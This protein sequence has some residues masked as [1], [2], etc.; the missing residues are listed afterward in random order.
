MLQLRSLDQDWSAEQVTAKVQGLVAFFRSRGLQSGQVVALN[1]ALTPD[2]IFVLLALW[3][4][5]AVVLPL[6]PRLPEA[7]LT[8]ALCQVEATFYLSERPLPGWL[9]LSWSELAAIPGKAGVWVPPEP[10]QAVSLIQTSGSS[11]APKLAQ[12]S[13]ANHVASAQGALSVLP[14][15]SSDRWLA[16]LPIYHVGGLAVVIRCLLAGATLCLPG[17]AVAV[18]CQIFRPTHLSLVPVQWAGLV[19]LPEAQPGF[20]SLQAVLLGGSAIPA[21]LL[22][23]SHARGLPVHSSYGSTEMSSQI[24]TTPP[25]ADLETLLTA[26]QVLPGRQLRLA[27]DGEIQVRGETLF[28]GYREGQRL[29]LP[30]TADGWFATRDRGAW[31]PAGYLQVL[32]RL[33]HVLISGG[34][35][36]QPEEIEALL[37]SQ[38]GIRQALVVGVPDPRW[39]QRPVAFLEGVWDTETLRQNLREQLPAFKIPDAFWPWPSQQGLKPSRQALTQQ[40]YTLQK[41][42]ST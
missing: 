11:G 31:S 25:G 28:M 36:I 4:V 30:L 16:I 5:G 13:W 18:A 21:A 22:Q 40:A 8:A 35:N 34:E 42:L 2:V 27:E 6:N 41:H 20:A 17:D 3:Q 1:S 19:D 24:A 9:T 37:L 33:D 7:A 10:T 26:G 32:G 29:H 23:R 38:P 15:A 14:L 12:H 39:G